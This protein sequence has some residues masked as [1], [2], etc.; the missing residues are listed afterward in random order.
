[1]TDLMP[2]GRWAKILDLASD[3]AVRRPEIYHATR[4]GRH[5]G[6]LERVKIWRAIGNLTRA[7]LLTHTRQ[8]FLATDDGRRALREAHRGQNG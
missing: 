4:S 8:G 2:E 3:R 7:G 6:K 1:M 5:P